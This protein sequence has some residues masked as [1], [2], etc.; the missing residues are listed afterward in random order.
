[1]IFLLRKLDSSELTA[2]RLCLT[3]NRGLCGVKRDEFELSHNALHITP[4]CIHEQ[5][6]TRQLERSHGLCSSYRKFYPRESDKSLAVQALCEEMETEYT[7]L[8]F[9][10]N[11]HWLKREKVFNQLFELFFL[12]K[13]LPRHGFKIHSWSMLMRWR[14]NSKKKFSI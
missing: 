13:R 6:T 3:V 10:I 1:M 8:L 12:L 11:V 4:I 7:V 5:I 9:H 2:H 14:R